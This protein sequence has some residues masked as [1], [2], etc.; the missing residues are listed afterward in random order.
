MGLT[1]PRLLLARGK[2]EAAAE[3]L[4][5]IYETAS[6]CGWGYGM[7]VVRI[8]QSLAAQNTD[9][10]MQYLSDALYR[11]E[12]ENFICSF[13]DAGQDVMPL[14]RE[15]AKR[16]IRREYANRILAEAGDKV[17]STGTDAGYPIEALSEREVEVLRL[18]TAGMSNREI[19]AKLF[20]SAGTAKTH[21]HHLCG[22]LGVRNRTA[23][24]MR[25]KELGLV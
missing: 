12:V 7:I 14:L 19:A 3:A 8:L 22:K 1:R 21:I 17:R 11:G 9:E 4:K 13:I 10:A 23:A 20:I 15:A 24:A 5:S 2:K 6:R 18:V 16:G 25:A